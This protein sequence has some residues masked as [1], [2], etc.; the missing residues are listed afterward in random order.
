[1]TMS[2]FSL[3]AS[4]VYLVVGGQCLWTGLAAR[5]L[6]R[7]GSEAAW[8]SGLA[9]LFVALFAWRVTGV[10]ESM[11]TVLRGMLRADGDYGAR[12]ELQGPLSAAAVLAAS[13]M[14]FLGWR[15]YAR[16]R[17]GSLT[18]L[19]AVARLAM[20]GLVG[21][22]ALRL[23]SLHVADKLLYG[24]AHLNWLID[25]GC[26]LVIGLCAFRYAHLPTRRR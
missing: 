8:W 10:E 12:Q 19:V 16:T 1:M 20:I 15:V 22:V 26:T 23:I 3:A 18:R 6:G 21:L 2:V 7:P 13:L 11:R 24:P 4:A 14:I 5:R 25:I 17:T 9:V